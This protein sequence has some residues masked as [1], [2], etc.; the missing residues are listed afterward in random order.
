[1]ANLKNDLAAF[2]RT[3]MCTFIMLYKLLED[4][5]IV[6]LH[7]R[8]LGLNTLEEPPKHMSGGVYCPLDVAS[9]GT[10]IG[11]NRDGLMMA[12]TN[13]ETQSIDKPGRSR[14]LLALDVLRECGSSA[15]AKDY[16]MDS[17]IRGFY[18]PGNF[19]VADAD[20]AWHVLWDHVSTAWKIPRGPYAMGVVTMY[21]GIVMSE[22]AERVG[23]DS[24]MR[25]KRAFHLLSHY[26]PASIDRAIE[27]MK[28]V[29]ADHEYGRTTSS[30]CW[31]STEFKQT[32]STIIA[33]GSKSAYSRVLYCV[34]NACESSFTEHPVLFG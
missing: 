18:R 5:P 4:Y 27:K 29:S 25:R 9:Q 3:P 8:Y 15:E 12:I 31:H 26:Q 6:A 32:S 20:D 2:I 1:V 34:G 7:N 22:R 13:Q 28:E 17:S 10:W 24:E 14:G 30:I 33:V 23:L 11:L 16:L 19:V 21:P